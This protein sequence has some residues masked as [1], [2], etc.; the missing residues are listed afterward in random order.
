MAVVVLFAVGVFGYAWLRDR[1]ED[2]RSAALA[3]YTPSA[4]VPDPSTQIP[5]VEVV[6]YRGGQHVA[7]TEQVAYTHSPPS[8]GAHDGMWAA[9][10]GVV[11]DQP[12]RSE[13]LVHS[14]EHGAVWITYN[15]ERL[16]RDGVE[17][18]AARVRDRP[19]SAMSP[20]PGLDQPISL[21]SWGHQLKL[22][23]PAD[24]RIDQFV[25]ALRANPNTHPEVGASCQALGP[26]RFDQDDPPPYRP[27]PPTSAMGQPGVRAEAES[28][29]ASGDNVAPMGGGS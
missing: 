24:P 25:A 21:Q 13:N 23:D 3:G 5:G 16:G 1:S 8:G 9:C 12:V 29:A 14:M 15:P 26:G 18:L 11:Y 17:Q 6:A 2:A 7:S 19:Y 10:T 28:T 27:A 4:A 22:A 20:Y